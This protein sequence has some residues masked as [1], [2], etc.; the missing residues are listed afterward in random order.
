MEQGE[1]SRA[2]MGA[3]K[4]RG[5]PRAGSPGPSEHP[6]HALCAMSASLPRQPFQKSPRS[7]SDLILVMGA[8]WVVGALGRGVSQ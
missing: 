6:P 3:G 5:R 4:D 1:G 8:G 7:L 2:G